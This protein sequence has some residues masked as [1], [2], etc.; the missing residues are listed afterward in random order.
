MSKR[1]VIKC[2]NC[3]KG[4]PVNPEKHLND[5]VIFCPWCRRPYTNSFF[6]P[7]WK[8]NEDYWKKREKRGMGRPFTIADLRR[9][10]GG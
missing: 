6:D 4:F 3:N 8:P 1:I 7:E 9:L 5:R 10:L 2:S